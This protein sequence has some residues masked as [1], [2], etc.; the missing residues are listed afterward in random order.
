MRAS[1]HTFPTLADTLWPTGARADLIRAAILAIVGSGLIAISAKIQVPFWPVPMTMQTFAVLVVG[2][3][4]GWKL[5]AATVLLYLAEGAVGLPVFAAGG[6]IAYFAG[7]TT[8]YLVGFLVA[9]TLVGW[10]GE[11]GWDRSVLRTLAANTLGTICIF[12]LGVAWL[13]LFLANAKALAF[14]AALGA[15]IANG[16]TPFIA[17]AAAKIALAAAVLPFAWKLVSRW[18][19]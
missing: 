14:D 2:M 7:P 19:G 4:Y 13:S 10:L 11:R 1:S 8:G 5:G 18:R 12:V 15:A 17:G 9:A 6:G 16:L 3:T